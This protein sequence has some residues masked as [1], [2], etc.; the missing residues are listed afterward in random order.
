MKNFKEVGEVLKTGTGW[1]GE[2]GYTI[3]R[4][5]ENDRSEVMTLCYNE[6]AGKY[7]VVIESSRGNVWAEFNTEDE[8]NVKFNSYLV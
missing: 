1:D 5:A 2:V 8:A 6:E 7:E 3:L 4:T